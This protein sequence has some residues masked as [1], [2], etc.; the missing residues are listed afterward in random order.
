MRAVRPRPAGAW[1]AVRPSVAKESG[2][3][4]VLVRLLRA[5]EGASQRVEQ[6]HGIV[7]L[8]WKPNK[9][10]V[11]V[12]LNES[13]EQMVGTCWYQQSRYEVSFF[14]GNSHTSGSPIENNQMFRWCW[15][16]PIQTDVVLPPSDEHLSTEKQEVRHVVILPAPCRQVCWGQ[17]GNMHNWLVVWN[18]FYFSIQLGIIIRTDDNIFQKGWNHQPEYVDEERDLFSPLNFTRFMMFNVLLFIVYYG[19]VWKGSPIELVTNNSPIFRSRPIL[20]RILI[21]H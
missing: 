2:G 8:P 3:G 18:M 7:F 10:V 13:L 4:Q 17:P 15:H 14:M 9:A 16:P 21:L 12:F 5:R 6:G 20:I 11:C 1:A 19:F